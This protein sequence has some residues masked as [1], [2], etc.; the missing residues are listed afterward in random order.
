MVFGIVT[1]TFSSIYVAGPVLLWIER[2]WP[3][4]AG[5]EGELEPAQREGVAAASDRPADARSARA[6]ARRS[7]IAFIE[8]PRSAAVRASMTEFI[9]S[10]VHL[11]DPAFD[12]DR[13]E[14]DRTRARRRA[15]RRSCASV[16]RSTPRGARGDLAARI[17]ASAFT[18]PACIRTTPP[19]S[20]ARATSP[21]SA[22]RSTRGAVAIGECGLD[23]HY[24]HSPRDQQRAAFAAQLALAQR[25]A[26]AGRRAHARSGR[27][28]ARHGRRGR[29]RRRASACCTATPAAPRSPRPRSTVGWYVSFSGI[30]TFRKWTDDALLRLVPDD[31]LLVESDAPYLAPV[32]HRGRAQRAGV[33]PV[34]RRPASLR[35]AA[36]TPRAL[37]ALTAAN[38]RRFFRLA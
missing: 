29:A 28:H 20:I 34:H 9:D 11:A 35:R 23:Y 15:R 1:G 31:R 24:D 14:V 10:H 3:R 2:E 13:E 26:A 32:P 17:R 4:N 6:D 33:G 38:A 25:A 19:T 37:G 8:P 7:V 21:A 16:N 12:D 36:S 18:P 22:P 30:V 27:R 5:R